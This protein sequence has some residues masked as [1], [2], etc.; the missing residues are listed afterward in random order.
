MNLEGSTMED[1]PSLQA[2]HAKFERYLLVERGMAKTTARMRSTIVRKCL[3]DWGTLNPTIEQVRMLKEDML[4]QGYVKDYVANVVVALRH[5][6]EY[7]GEDLA[8]KPP[9]QEKKKVPRFLSEEEVQSILF[10]IDSTRD[11]ALFSVLAYTG[12]R[13]QELCNLKRHEMD[14]EKK[15]VT[16]QHGKGGRSDEVPIGGPALEA[17][18]RY[19]RTGVPNEASPYLFHAPDG[20]ALSTNRVRVLTR[21]YARQAGIRKSVSPHMFRHAL[22][23][24]LLSKGCPLPFVQRQLR[25]SRI[26][27][28]MRYLHLSDKALRDNYERF[29]P[30]Y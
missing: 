4:I 1:H 12:L 25:H 21:K 10:V 27:T 30:E 22:A 23:T 11:Q 17:T 6:G 3:R 19:L 20:T 16:V 2:R 15:T 28:T 24:N 26:E 7:M 8:V 13:C 5:Y 9:A 18:A 29:M 14:F